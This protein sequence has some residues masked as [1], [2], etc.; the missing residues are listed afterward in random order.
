M[1]KSMQRKAKA[2]VI[3]QHVI[4]NINKKDDREFALPLKLKGLIFASKLG[5]WLIT[6]ISYYGLVSLTP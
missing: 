4:C 5:C 6:F 2:L 3:K 1:G